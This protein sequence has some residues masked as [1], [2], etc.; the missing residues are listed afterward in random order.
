MFMHVQ[1]VHVQ[2]RAQSSAHDL[3]ELGGPKDTLVLEARGSVHAVFRSQLRLGRCQCYTEHELNC[4]YVL[5]VTRRSAQNTFN[6]KLLTN[7][8]DVRSLEALVL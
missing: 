1:L 5:V 4:R 8:I 6:L 7:Y 3:E 2:T